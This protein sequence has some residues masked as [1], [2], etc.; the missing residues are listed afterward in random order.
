MSENTEQKKKKKKLLIFLLLLISL[1]TTLGILFVN[2]KNNTIPE[3]IS[4]NELQPQINLNDYNYITVD[5]NSQIKVYF[6]EDYNVVGY[7]FVDTKAEDAFKDLDLKNKSIEKV[8]YSLFDTAIEK[9]YIDEFDFDGDV[10]QDFVDK[11]LT[12]TI[13]EVLDSYVKKKEESIR[14]TYHYPQIN[15]ND[16][17]EEKTEI[18]KNISDSV[19]PTPKQTQEVVDSGTNIGDGGGF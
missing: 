17:K 8:L 3:P 7:V 19:S 5:A 1:L 13:T 2:S 12:K 15:D 10:Y 18:F 6:D 4:N 11:D 9:G 14:I 16:K